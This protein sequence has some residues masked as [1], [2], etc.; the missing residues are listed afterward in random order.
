[1]PYFSCISDK[2]TF[3]RCIPIAHL[4]RILLC[5]HYF[6]IIK[7]GECRSQI[8]LVFGLALFERCYAIFTSFWASPYCK[9]IVFD[10]SAVVHCNFLPLHVQT[11]YLQAYFPV[12]Y[13]F[14][15]FL[16]SGH[17]MHRKYRAC[18]FLF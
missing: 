9:R 1:M 15:A 7:Y 16:T 11:L 2:T 10:N 8:L 13:A 14:W 5:K 4:H 3:A 6:S 12:F 17:R 18:T